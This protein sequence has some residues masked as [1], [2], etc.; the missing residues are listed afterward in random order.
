MSVIFIAR[1]TVTLGRTKRNAQGKAIEHIPAQFLADDNGGSI[2]VG[3]LDPD[4]MQPQDNPAIYSDWDTAGYFAE[5]RREL[6]PTRPSNIPD[7]EAIEKAMSEDNIC[8][9]DYCKRVDTFCSECIV[10][11]WIEE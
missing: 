2:V 8:I 5:V 9:C 6:G 1:G 7:F 10:R 11:E 4:T 3:T